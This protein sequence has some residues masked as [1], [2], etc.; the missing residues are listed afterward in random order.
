MFLLYF[1]S[2]N[3]DSIEIGNIDLHLLKYVKPQIQFYD[4]KYKMKHEYYFKGDMVNWSS[5]RLKGQFIIPM[6]WGTIRIHLILPPAIPNG[7]NFKY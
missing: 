1:N 2:Y 6:K 5:L 3:T 7:I 4:F